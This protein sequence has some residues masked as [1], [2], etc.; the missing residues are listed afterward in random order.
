MQI[1]DADRPA[2]CPAFSSFW[3]RALPESVWSGKKPEKH[4]ADTFRHVPEIHIL[5]VA[6][7]F[8]DNSPKPTESESP[9]RCRFCGACGRSS[10]L[11]MKS[12]PIS[13]YRCR[14]R[15]G[16]SRRQPETADG[17]TPKVRHPGRS[18]EWSCRPVCILA[19]NRRGWFHRYAGPEMWHLWL[20]R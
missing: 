11:P 12:H 3:F 5:L 16:R 14:L 10:G 17:R 7:E 13:K 1:L 18:H 20:I 8:S 2:A 6:E 4:R 9:Y 19:C 15:S